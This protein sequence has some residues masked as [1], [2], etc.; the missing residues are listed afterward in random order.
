MIETAVSMVSGMLVRIVSA[1]VA[2]SEF[3]RPGYTSNWTRHCGKSVVGVLAGEKE[4]CRGRA[5][6]LLA[7]VEPEVTAIEEQLLALG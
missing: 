7:G 2:S 4:A 3:E 5:G 1:S 6:R